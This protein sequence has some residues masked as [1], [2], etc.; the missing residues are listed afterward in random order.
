MHLAAAIF[1]CKNRRPHLQEAGAGALQIVRGCIEVIPVIGSLT[2]LA[3]DT[4]QIK[5]KLKDEFVKSF[6]DCANK[7]QNINI[8]IALFKGYDVTN[9]A[10]AKS[11]QGPN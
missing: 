1:D 7:W 2:V 6:P 5:K 4:L 3:L 10:L 11:L 9:G 8:A